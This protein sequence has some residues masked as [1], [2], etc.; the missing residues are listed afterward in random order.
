MAKH[1]SVHEY[2]QGYQSGAVDRTACGLKGTAGRHMTDHSANG[3]KRDLDANCSR[4]QSV[5]R[6]IARSDPSEK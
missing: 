2:A 1:V 5:L 4:C 3:A 6:T